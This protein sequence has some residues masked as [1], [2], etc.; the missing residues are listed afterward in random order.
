VVFYR[1]ARREL[2]MLILV[3]GLPATGKSTL[4]RN[5]SKRLKGILLRTDII[6]KE[7][8]P[9]PR[10]TAEE[11]LLVYNILTLIAWYLLLAKQTVIIDGTFYK[12]D[13]RDQ[14]YKLANRSGRPFYVIQC[15]C[16]DRVI[17]E[18]MSR[19]TGKRALPTDADYSVYLKIK[20]EFEPI[21]RD[22]IVVDTTRPIR[23]A[24]DFVMTQLEKR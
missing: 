20:N 19:R 17:Q 2:L 15:V 18:R 12:K 14:I 1:G 5:L 13:L 22:H 11:K 23:G 6:R 21:E 8:F 16:S 10:Y 3:C 7:V 4:A 9:E 24:V